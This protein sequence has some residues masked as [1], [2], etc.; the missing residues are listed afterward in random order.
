MQLDSL[1][2]QTYQQFTLYIHDDGS[3]DR[4]VDILQEAANTHGNILLLDYPAVHDV[5]ENFLS[6]LSYVT[7]DYILFC[8]QDDIWEPTKITQLMDSMTAFEAAY[9]QCPCLVFSDASLINT[10][11]QIIEKSHF[12]ADVLRRSP[13]DV[14]YQQLMGDNIGAG[15]T[16][17][18]NRKLLSLIFS[19]QVQRPSWLYHDRL[20]MLLASIYGKI[21][22]VDQPLVKYRIHTQNVVGAAKQIEKQSI[23]KRFQK[24][25]EGFAQYY[26]VRMM[27]LGEYLRSRKDLP[28]TIRAELD[29]LSFVMNQ[30]KVKRIHFFMRNKYMTGAR[31]SRWEKI[32]KLLLFLPSS[33]GKKGVPS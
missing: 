33:H 27:E 2:A 28:P 10:H 13:Q 30:S 17:L 11:G 26:L 16:F 14:N 32:M 9:P 19:Q 21:V 15:N 31:H 24:A 1:F 12:A 4:T 6:I 20:V 23:C 7:E 22:Y 5:A 29:Q 3:S 8:D 25:K 18:F